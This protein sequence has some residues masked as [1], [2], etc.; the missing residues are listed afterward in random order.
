MSSQT[1]GSICESVRPCGVSIS[2]LKTGVAF[3]FANAPHNYVFHK[4]LQHSDGWDIN[5]DRSKQRG[6]LE[7]SPSEHVCLMMDH[8]VGRSP[9]MMHRIGTA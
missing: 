2:D 7:Y 1:S 9:V 3:N 8:E 6:R 4:M 5:R